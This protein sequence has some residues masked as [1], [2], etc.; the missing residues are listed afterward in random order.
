MTCNGRLPAHI[1]LETAGAKVLGAT[2]WAR[3]NQLPISYR[4]TVLVTEF[5][6]RATRCG[7]CKGLVEY[8]LGGVRAD[9]YY[10]DRQTAVE[11][12]TGSES[13]KCLQAK[14]EGYRRLQ[15]VRQVVLV[16]QGT[17]DRL[18]AF[19]TALGGGVGAEFANLDKLLVNLC[20]SFA[21]EQR[22]G[23]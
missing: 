5:S 21:S 12:D 4:H 15:N 6:I 7:I 23:F 18:T 10:P 2:S 16:T 17:K 20:R 3:I 19:L 22:K 14:A 9:L 11:I 1:T 8:D 13:Q